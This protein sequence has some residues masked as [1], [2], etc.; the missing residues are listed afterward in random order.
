MNVYPC[1]SMC[2]YVYVCVCMC[3]YVYECVSMCMY[4]YIC[5][6]MC[7]YVYVC[8]C[9]CMYVYV[10]TRTTIREPSSADRIH[11]RLLPFRGNV[12]TDDVYYL[13]K[14][15]YRERAYCIRLYRRVAFI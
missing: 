12:K 8:V 2:I 5:V 1:V 3:M 14:K 10:C 6:Y 11:N 7:M 15:R 13:S 9:M 4:V